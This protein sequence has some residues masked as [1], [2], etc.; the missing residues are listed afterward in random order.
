MRSVDADILHGDLTTDYKRHA[1]AISSSGSDNKKR[2]KT[3]LNVG[4]NT[5]SS[6]ERPSFLDSASMGAS[7]NP[8]G[9]G[10][11]ATPK[12]PVTSASN[13]FVAACMVISPNVFLNNQLKVSFLLLHE[14]IFCK[15]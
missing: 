15:C 2:V 1:D 11:V 6:V 4:S 9:N 8:R 5:L 14:L 12:R 10:S 7:G 13:M 3:P